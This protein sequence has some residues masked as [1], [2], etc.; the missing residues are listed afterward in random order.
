MREV[1]KIVFNKSIQFN[2]KV[3]NFMILIK[4]LSLNLHTLQIVDLTPQ[5]QYPKDI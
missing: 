3:I 4:L 5:I 1:T 2:Y